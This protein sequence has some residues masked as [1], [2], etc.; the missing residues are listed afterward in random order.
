MV[1]TALNHDLLNKIFGANDASEDG[2]YIDLQGNVLSLPSNATVPSGISPRERFYLALVVNADNATTD[3]FV[4][5]QNLGAL[6]VP[7]SSPPTQA[8]LFRD[9][10]AS[11]RF[12][13]M[14]GT[15]DAVRI[16]TGARTPLEIGLT[17]ALLEQNPG[18]DG[19][20]ADDVFSIDTDT[21]ARLEL[22]GT[23]LDSGDFGA[24]AVL[25]GAGLNTEFVSS[26]FGRGLA[27]SAPGAVGVDWTEHAARL[28]PPWT[29]EMVLQVTPAQNPLTKRLFT[30]DLTNDGGWYWQSLLRFPPGNPVLGNAP[31][32]EKLEY[33][34]F[35]SADGTTMDVYEDGAPLGTVGT[36]FGPG[37]PV[38]ALFFKD[39]RSDDYIGLV[40]ALRISSLVR[41][42]QDIDAVQARLQTR[43]PEHFEVEID[44]VRTIFDRNLDV[45]EPDALTTVITGKT[46][47]GTETLTVHADW[48]HGA[49]GTNCDGT[50]YV[51]LATPGGTFR[52]DGVTAGSDCAPFARRYAPLPGGF[53]TGGMTATLVN[54]PNTKVLDNAAFD[55][56]RP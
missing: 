43:R 7:F 9:D 26:Q 12:Q 13:S 36:Q 10:T 37:A 56:R 51:T 15:I 39:D 35:A 55:V 22:N 1:A 33:F 16:S 31:I 44:G 17:Q 30:P 4:D 41:S 11:S 52:A 28:V 3:V 42:Q 54:G 8:L 14:N 20:G 32:T 18:G 21:L 53:I 27:I 6:P 45:T 34:V 40:D 46:A 29:I 23:T 25:Y 49:F 5:G 2:W 24:D 48:A 50:A 38:N 19:P 47:D